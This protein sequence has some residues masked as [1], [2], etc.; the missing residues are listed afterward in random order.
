M[1]AAALKYV[2][3]CPGWSKEAW[4]KFTETFGR[5]HVTLKFMLQYFFWMD[6]WYYWIWDMNLMR[7]VYHVNNVV[8]IIISI[9]FSWISAINSKE[10]IKW[11]GIPKPF[12][13]FLSS[14]QKGLHQADR[15][16]GTFASCAGGLL[17]EHLWAQQCDPC[18]AWVGGRGF[19]KYT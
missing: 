9:W 5:N 19:E 4:G 17:C 3:E 10:T 2:E 1:K 13:L 18:F 8:F 15:H 6:M 14:W 12:S 11:I 7:R 16:Q